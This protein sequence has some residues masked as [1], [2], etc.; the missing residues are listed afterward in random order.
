MKILTILLP[1]LRLLPLKRKTLS[2]MTEKSFLM[3][4]T[5]SKTETKRLW[6]TLS[7]NQ[8]TLHQQDTTQE[9][10]HLP[11]GK[12][13]SHLTGGE[14]DST[15]ATLSWT[16]SMTTEPSWPHSWL[17]E[18]WHWPF[19]SPYP[20]PYMFHWQPSSFLTKEKE[21]FWLSTDGLAPSSH[22]PKND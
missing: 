7:T 10:S 12:P 22:Q 5:L 18:D 19:S 21:S 9:K 20:Q 8:E 3:K 6:N 16:R 15:S 11:T 17:L 13:K 2:T 4:S 14:S 1:F